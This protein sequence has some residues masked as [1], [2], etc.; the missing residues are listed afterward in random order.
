MTDETLPELRSMV[1][2]YPWFQLARILLLLNVSKVSP[3]DLDRELQVQAPFI[4][5]KRHLYKLLN[6]RDFVVE[7]FELLP[8]DNSFDDI[9]GK[10]E[11]SEASK[12]DNIT[13]EH[14]EPESNEEPLTIEEEPFSLDPIEIDYAFFNKNDDLFQLEDRIIQEDS[15]ADLIDKFIQNMPQM[16][17]LK[18]VP[19]ERNIDLSEHSV[20]ESDDLIT[21]TLAKIYVEQGY[22]EKAIKAFEKLSLKFPEKNSYFATQIEEIKKI[23][24]KT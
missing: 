7:P 15:G 4:T 10:T 8:L 11:E 5:D 24:N 17:R 9:V 23:T 13:V 18:D 19:K 16:G 3:E 6:Q 2:R 14:S 1:N 20:D 22:Y 12:T 21:E